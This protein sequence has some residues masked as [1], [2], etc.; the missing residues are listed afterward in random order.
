MVFSRRLSLSSLIELCRALRHYLQAGLT[1]REVFKQQSKRGTPGVRPVAVRIRERLED[2]SDLEGA[3]KSETH[4]FPPLFLSLATIGEETGMLPEVCRELERYFT[5]QRSLWRQFL[6]FI[7]WPVF[8]LVAAIFVV[9]GLIWILGIV[10]QMNPGG[11]QFDPIGLGTG[12]GSALAFFFGSWGTLTVGAVLFVLARRLFREGA[13]DGLLL[14]LP[15]LG[16]CLRSLALTRFCLALRLTLE[17]GMPIARA[18]RLAMQATSNGAFAAGAGVVVEAVRAGED[19]TMALTAPRLFPTDF[20]HVISV[21]EESGRLTE[22]L[23]QQ[24]QQFHEE[25]ERRLRILAAVASGLV[26]L[27]VAGVIVLAIFR[28]F[29]TYI[30]LLDPSHY[31]L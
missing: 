11:L 28:I 8:Q 19:L 25:S 22:V 1:L 18:V 20:L 26:W 31:G 21:G 30:D 6:G 24:G 27:F 14:R 16:P 9:T 4:V 5:L 2:G 17:T 13:V 15:A 23:E 29:L 7:A 10:A 12:A 3:L